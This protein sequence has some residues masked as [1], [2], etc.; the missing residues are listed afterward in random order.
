MTKKLTDE[1]IE[2]IAVEA[3]RSA[4]GGP[5]GVIG[6]ARLRNL[7]AYNAEP[8]G[9]FAPPEIADRSDFVDTTVRDTVNGMLPQLMRMFIS[10]DNAVEF[11]AKAPESEGMAKL[12]TAFVNHLFYV[13]NDG[14]GIVSDWFKDALLQKVGF[15][16]VWAEE[17]AEDAKQRY[18]GQTLEQLAMLVQEGWQLE[19]DPEQDESGL[20]FIVRKESRS[21]RIRVM[22]CP[23]ASMRVDANARWDDDPAMIGQSHYKR[24]FQLEEEGYDLADVSSVDGPDDSEALEQLGEGDEACNEA[25]HRSHKL[26]KLDEVYIKLDADGDGVA[27]WLK[28]CLLNDKLAKYEDGS[29]AVEQVDDH[30]FVWICPTPRPHAFFGDCPADYAYAA[31]KL[32]TTVVRAMDDN[33]VQ[34]VN[35]R[36]YINLNADVNIDDVLDNRPNGVIRGMQPMGEAL[37]TLAVPNMLGPAYQFNEYIGSWAE[38]ATGFNRYSA[39]TDQNALNKTARGTELLTAKADMRMELIARYFAVGMRG[40]FAKMLKL[41][42]QYQNATDMVK[43]AGQFVPINPGDFRD[44][45]FVK[46]NVGLGNG[47]KE[48][49]M[50]RLMAMSQMLFGPGIQAGVV[51]PKHVSEMIRLGFELNEFKQPD[52]FVDAEPSGMPPNPQAFQ[53]MQQQA[54]QQ[55][56]QM[57][58]RLQELEQENAALKS[59]MKDK[60]A[61][62]A[63]KSREL[64]MKDTEMLAKLAESEHRAGLSERQQGFAE[65][66]AEDKSQ[67]AAL[68][69]QVQAITAYLQQL[70][71]PVMDDEPGMDAGAAPMEEA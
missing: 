58:Q 42:V 47:S 37:G 48:Q 14:V 1:Q 30:P 44:D 59:Q 32:R 7:R 18:E 43:V 38:N 62:F 15:V 52:R 64:E 19:G 40:L 56:Q 33:L 68:W 23:P 29:S 63:L 60:S 16:K 57:G 4:I 53:Q 35:A 49:Q 27:E 67:I 31:Q 39:G 51:Q 24:R 71:Q 8:K 17:Y 6:K 34:S 12:A 36:T 13:K 41:A 70:T 5:D 54:Q 45:F 2:G 55:A 20:S 61:D 21:R 22:A 66:Q 3:M 65:S 9:E 69:D 50:A 46:I 28:V 11:E 10:S 25:P 26:V